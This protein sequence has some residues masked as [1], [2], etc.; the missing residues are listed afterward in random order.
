MN[1][2]SLGQG[3]PEAASESGSGFIRCWI[4]SSSA[5]A[6]DVTVKKLADWL[7]SFTASLESAPKLYS[8]EITAPRGDET[9]PWQPCWKRLWLFVFLNGEPKD[10]DFQ[11]I[12]DCFRGLEDLGVP[13]SYGIVASNSRKEEAR[14]FSSQHPRE[15]NDDSDS[16]EFLK[17]SCGPF[18]V[19]GM[20]IKDIQRRWKF[21]T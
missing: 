3:Q 7:E 16:R 6:T 5:L 15:A 2:K 4:A 21:K 10:E 14:I 19:N 11:E 9:D 1:A 12:T 13:V 17:S 20:I 8:K 18:L